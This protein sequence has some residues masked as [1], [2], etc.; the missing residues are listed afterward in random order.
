MGDRHAM[1]FS[2]LGLAPNL[3]ENISKAGYETPTPIQC[4]AIPQVLAKR[5]VLDKVYKSRTSAA[6]ARSNLP[7]VTQ[8]DTPELDEHRAPEEH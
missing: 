8:L 1:D 2:A 7:K 5:D 3:L 6:H 4:E